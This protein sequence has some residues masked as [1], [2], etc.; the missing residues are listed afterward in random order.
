LTEKAREFNTEIV[1]IEVTFGDG[2]VMYLKG[3]AL[4][5]W[6]TMLLLQSDYLL[7]GNAAHVLA[8]GLG[9]PMPEDGDLRVWWIRNVPNIPEYHMVAT[10]NE[11]IVK[12]NE[13]ADK[14]LADASVTDNAG[15]LEKFLNGDWEE[16]EDDDGNSIDD[17]KSAREEEVN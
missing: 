1:K 13:L 12:L 17:V 3:E 7:P 9:L 11:A 8:E 4:R 15:G 16:W 5:Q 10:I 6:Q 2:S 14:D